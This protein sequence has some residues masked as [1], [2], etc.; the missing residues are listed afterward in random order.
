MKSEGANSGCYLLQMMLETDSLVSVGA[1]GELTFKAGIYFYLGRAKRN[2]RQR[3]ERHLRG[4]KK[5]RW[6][7]DYLLQRAVI[8][9]VLLSGSLDERGFARELEAHKVLTP[10]PRFGA[11]DDPGAAR[12]FTCSSEQVSALDAHLVDLGFNQA[13]IGGEG[14]Q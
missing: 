10:I 14:P 9:R 6:H 11:S 1:L 3:V 8:T 12:L 5:L 7:V 4:K 2:L 13:K